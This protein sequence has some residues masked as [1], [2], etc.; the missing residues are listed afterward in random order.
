MLVAARIGLAFNDEFV[1]GGDEPVG[2]GLAARSGSA[3]MASHSS[4]VRFD[5][6][7]VEARRWRPTQSP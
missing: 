4:A 3:I 5:V 6:T 7:M 2:G 1:G